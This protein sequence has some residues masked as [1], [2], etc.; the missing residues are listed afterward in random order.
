VQDQSFVRE[1][2]QHGVFLLNPY[3]KL[4]GSLNGDT[5]LYMCETDE[6]IIDQANLHIRRSTNGGTTFADWSAAGDVISGTME[7]DLGYYQYG[8]RDRFDV[9]GKPGMYAWWRK[10]NKLR[11]LRTTTMDV[12]EYTIP[13]FVSDIWKSDGFTLHWPF[14]PGQYY[15]AQMADHSAGSPPAILKM[16]VNAEG[17]TW[18]DL[19]GN[20]WSFLYLPTVTTKVLHH[21]EV[22]GFCPHWT[23]T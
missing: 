10:E 21:A 13:G 1:S 8:H 9:P 19:T 3:W 14:N 2:D 16:T 5:E 7:P 20:M 12:T 18:R 17:G 11:V 15:A 4:D 23:E 6:Y 22:M